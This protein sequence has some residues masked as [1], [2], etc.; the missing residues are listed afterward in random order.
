MVALTIKQEEAHS[1]RVYWA[2]CAKKSIEIVQWLDKIDPN[3]YTP[4]IHSYLLSLLVVSDPRL[5]EVESY[6][7]EKPFINPKPWQTTRAIV[8]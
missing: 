2:L 4:W 1:F 5:R 3:D 6:K 8:N 7:K